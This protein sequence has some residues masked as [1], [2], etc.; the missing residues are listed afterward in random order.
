MQVLVDAWANGRTINEIVRVLP[1]RDYKSITRKAFR[2]GLPSRRT[3]KLYE[4]IDPNEDLL[5]LDDN[6][7]AWAYLDMNYTRDE[8]DAVYAAKPKPKLHQAKCKNCGTFCV[9]ESKFQRWCEPCRKE[10]NQIA[11]DGY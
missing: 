2:L 9:F 5:E 3:R 6:D 4:A 1:K 11:D 10:M 7:P 8:V